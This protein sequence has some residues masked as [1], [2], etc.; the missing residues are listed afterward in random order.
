[1][2]F[3][4]VASV[5]AYSSLAPWRMIPPHSWCVPG[6]KPGTSVKVEYLR[7]GKTLSANAKLERRPQE[8][9]AGGPGRRRADS[10]DGVLD[11]VAVTDI[12]PEMRDQ[13]QI[14][15]RVQGAIVTQID[16]S[17]PSAQQGLREGDVILEL[18]R[19]PVK[20]AED[21]VEL[22]AKIKGPKVMVRV[23]REG[24]SMYLVVDES[25]E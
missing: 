23:W 9:L 5:N 24:R 20:N 10:D 17:S 2:S 1:M 21:A 11:G 19:K 13:L 18:D 25:T 6:K 7:D 15:T 12:S 8:T 4:T 16:P 3:G 14:P 22:S